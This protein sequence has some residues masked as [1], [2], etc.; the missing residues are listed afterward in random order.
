LKSKE[1][2][3]FM[4]DWYPNDYEVAINANWLQEQLRELAKA[5]RSISVLKNRIEILETISILNSTIEYRINVK[6]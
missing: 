6:G 4:C 2:D 1:L 3:Q 5:N